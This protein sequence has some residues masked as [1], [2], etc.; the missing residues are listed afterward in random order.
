MKKLYLALGLFFLLQPCAHAGNYNNYWCGMNDNGPEPITNNANFDTGC[1]IGALTAI[2]TGTN[3]TALGNTAGDVITTGSN[4]TILGGTAGSQILK[5]GS[6]NILIGTGAAYYPNLTYSISGTTMT[7]TAVSGGSLAPGD[8]ING[9]ASANTIITNYGTGTGGTGTYIVNNSQTVTSNSSYAYPILDAPLASTSNYLNI[10]NT[11]TGTLNGTG[12]TAG[13]TIFAPTTA[14]GA[15]TSTAT[16]KTGG[17]TVSTLPTGAV[18]MRA[19]VTDQTTACPAAGGALT[20]SGSVT[21]PVFF[22]GT[23]WK[24]D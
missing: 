23:S 13:I 17:Y 5:T 2:T 6:N 16:I 15:L 7:V 18:G 22:D 14:Y 11:I 10:G 8:L 24:G 20:G 12:G 21:C 1:G 3:D 9:S 4:N 19:Y